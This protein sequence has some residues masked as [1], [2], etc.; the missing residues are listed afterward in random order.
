MSTVCAP[1]DAFYEAVFLTDS[2]FRIVT[3]NLRAVELFRAVSRE[4]LIGRSLGG[5]SPEGAARLSSDV[6]RERLGREPFV[7]SEGRAMRDDGTVFVAE[8]AVH[9]LDE[10]AVLVTVRDVTRR[11]EALHRAEEA[12]ERLRATDRDRMEFVS[13]V[14]HEL[15]TPLTSM[16]YALTNMLRGVCGPLPERAVGYLERL[17]ADVR[18]LT[19][20]VNDIL[21]LRQ[22]ENGTL[23]LRKTCLPLGRL[24]SEAADAL[25]V[26][27]EVKRQCLEVVQGER[28]VYALVDR[29]K[30]ERV[31]FNLLSNAVKYTPEGG[32]IHALLCREGNRARVVVDD[33]GIG[34]PPEAL[35][36]VS[37]RYFRVGD[38]V[39]GTGLGLSIVR[40]IIELHG[41]T[42]RLESPVPGTEHGTRA[43]VELPVCE[44]P[45]LVV[46]S[47]NDTFVQT[48]TKAAEALG[49]GVLID[50]SGRNLPKAC[51]DRQPA[52]FVLDGTLP[53]G[54]LDDL[55]CQ[56]RQNVRL[57]RT[58]ILLLT[59]N[60][61]K[62]LRRREYTRMRVNV[63]S[64]PLASEALCALLRD[65]EDW[66]TNEKMK[67]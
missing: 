57:S 26:Q 5:F 51:G 48:L 11:V 16:S 53:E 34:I 55:V 7:L 41:G 32:T 20:T 23:T 24:L 42:L 19:T 8:V 56:I 3:C 36:R 38:Q 28:E 39:A 60:M 2:D 63:C 61:K 44:E 21:D 49:N 9:R 50:R 29:N 35:P 15:R 12:N 37:Q 58:P 30:I 33:N 1:L 59:P 18:R 64:L 45:L 4:S 17:Q 52:R 65:V 47:N 13:N 43:M 6:F 67:A 54:M 14:S 22:L 31:F 40:E 66:Q 46:V 27:A 10:S 62:I 25:S